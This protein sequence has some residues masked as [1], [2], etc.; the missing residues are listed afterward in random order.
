MTILNTKVKEK[1]GLCLSVSK[2]IHQY[3][4]SP[5][6]FGEHFSQ[7]NSEYEMEQDPVVFPSLPCPLSTFCM[8]ETLIRE[9]R[10]CRN[11]GKWSNKMK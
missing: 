8:W 2:I 3:F 1:P 11:K 10:K 7:N 5:C 6:V 4:L 9:V